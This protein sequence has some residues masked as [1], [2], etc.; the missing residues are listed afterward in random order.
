M[1]LIGPCTLTSR[2]ETLGHT[3]AELGGLLPGTRGWHFLPAPAFDAVRPTLAAVQEAT[4]GLQEVMP[5]DATLATMREEE[6]AAFVRTAI[7]S[8]PGAA[9]FLELMD[10]LDALALE[11]RDARGV[12][13]PTRTLGVTELALTPEAFRQM[14]ATIDPSSDAKLAARPPFYLLVAG[15]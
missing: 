6:R 3:G 13:V 5:T 12:V 2:G 11:L 9:R 8:D 7:M 15:V 1:D 14:L 10:E 4:S